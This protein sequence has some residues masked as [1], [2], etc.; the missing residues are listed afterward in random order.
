MGVVF[1]PDKTDHVD[2][3]VLED[4]T[5]CGCEVTVA[6][7]EIGMFLCFLAVHPDLITVPCVVDV[8][9]FGQSHAEEALLQ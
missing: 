1:V 7:T 3:V 8:S 6:P 4:I 9:D 5:V 2:F